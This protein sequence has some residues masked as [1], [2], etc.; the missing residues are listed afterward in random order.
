L[1]QDRQRRGESQKAMLERMSYPSDDLPKA[2]FDQRMDDLDLGKEVR[3][4]ARQLQRLRKKQRSG[5][6]LK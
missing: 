4:S 5:Q 2:E 6:I 1:E 3:R